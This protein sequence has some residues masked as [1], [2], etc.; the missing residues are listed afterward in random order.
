MLSLLRQKGK[1][2]TKEKKKIVKEIQD[3]IFFQLKVLKMEITKENMS[4]GTTIF[5]EGVKYI[6]DK[7]IEAQK[8]LLKGFGYKND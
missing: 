3:I 1:M 6:K 8:K 4:F 7:E 5:I 2:K